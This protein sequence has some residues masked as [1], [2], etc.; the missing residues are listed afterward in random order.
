MNDDDDK[1]FR[2]GLVSLIGPLRGYARALVGQAVAADDLVQEAMLRALRA[3]RQFVPG[4]ELRAWLF[5]ILRHTWLESQ[6]RLGREQRATASME[7]PAPA[8]ASQGDGMAL[9]RLAAALKALPA[10]QR[11]AVLLVGAQGMSGAEAARICGVAE[12][13]LRARVSRARQALRRALIQE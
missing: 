5:T 7:P 10:L 6:R 4:S 13:T 1:A 12:G 2:A 11:E 9:D 8:G 3:H